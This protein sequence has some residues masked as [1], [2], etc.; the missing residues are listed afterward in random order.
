MDIVL[1]FLKYFTSVENGALMTKMNGWLSP[2][3]GSATS[4]NASPQ[5]IQVLDEINK[6]DAMAIWLDTVTNINVANA[7]L[8]GAEALLGGTK[9]P[10]QV[11]A[12]VQAGAAKA[13]VDVGSPAP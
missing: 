3:K 6:A 4:D 11:M 9:T 2:I 7:Y 8:N 10:A 13:K 12:D 5:L 1:D